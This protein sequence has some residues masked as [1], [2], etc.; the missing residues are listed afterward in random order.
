MKKIEEPGSGTRI[1]FQNVYDS[2]EWK[3]LA[4]NERA[5][6]ILVAEGKKKG[7]IIM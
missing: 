4:E 2:P 1:A 6:L 7:T 5:Q 3:E